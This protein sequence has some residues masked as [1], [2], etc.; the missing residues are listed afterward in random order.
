MGEAYQGLPNT[1]TAW[2]G[3]PPQT[4]GVFQR[5]VHSLSKPNED[6]HAC[7]GQTLPGYGV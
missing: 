5:S 2:L 4:E 3:L 6:F 1:V 7:G